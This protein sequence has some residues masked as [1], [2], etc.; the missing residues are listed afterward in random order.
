MAPDLSRE[1][2]P[3]STALTTA[4]TLGRAHHRGRS[5]SSPANSLLASCVDESH[6]TDA[7]GETE[8]PIV[9]ESCNHFLVVDNRYGTPI[10]VF[11]ELDPTAEPGFPGFGVRAVTLETNESESGVGVP[12]GVSIGRNPLRLDQ[13]R[14][15]GTDRAVSGAGFILIEPRYVGPS[16]PSYV[17]AFRPGG[18][19]PIKRLAME[20]PF[21]NGSR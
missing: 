12:A 11:L 16:W 20:R 17:L 6:T 5:W 15:F 3:D 4:L 13:F 21:D 1:Q 19:K 10:Y 14:T 9:P 8:L 18:D 2:I 7:L